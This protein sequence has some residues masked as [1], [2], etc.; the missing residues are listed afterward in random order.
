MG[1]HG[2]YFLNDQS[3]RLTVAELLYMKSMG[4]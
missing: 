3:S 1:E 2:V 4:S